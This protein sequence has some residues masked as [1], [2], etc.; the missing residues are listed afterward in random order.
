MP[1]KPVSFG[2]VRE[3]LNIPLELIVAEVLVNTCSPS[4]N[5][6]ITSTSS[7]RGLI[8]SNPEYLTSPETTISLSPITF[9]GHNGSEKSCNALLSDQAFNEMTSRSFTDAACCAEPVIPM[10]GPSVIPSMFEADENQ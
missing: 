10:T 6:R 9:N 3:A 1:L 8:P 4:S 7:G 5:S 2:V